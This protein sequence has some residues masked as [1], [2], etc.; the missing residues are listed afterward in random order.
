MKTLTLTSPLT[1]NASVREAQTLLTSGKFGNFSPGPIDGEYGEVAA[2]ATR[3]AKFA[4]GYPAASLNE[5]FGALLEAYL[6]GKKPL[7][8]TYQ[9]RAK[10]REPQELGLKALASA[11]TQIGV[12]ES[13]AGS[14]DQAYGKWYGANG[15][16][17][18]AEFVSW[19][20]A[21]SGSKV[22]KPGAYAYCP[23]IL[24]DAKAGVNNLLIT[25]D[26][27]P[28]D[29]VLYCWDGT[30]VPEHTG[31]FE[32]WTNQSAGQF[33]AVE[34]NTA[35]GNDSNG[36]EVMRRDRTTSNVVAFVHCKN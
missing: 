36:G 11:I 10:A 3:R 33:E 23:Y 9:I 16:P 34:G 8:K 24:R 29:I 1:K 4:L 35:V 2:A 15:V 30:G 21:R 31:L 26:P 12:K 18:C 19:N 17:W 14:N 22:F 27:Q 5:A 7:P 28:G 32:D 13:P 25:K 20:Y 6:S